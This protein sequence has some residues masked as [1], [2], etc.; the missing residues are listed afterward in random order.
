MIP[1]TTLE[2][3]AATPAAILLGPALLEAIV[4]WPAHYRLSAVVP[5]LTR[6]GHKVCR[7]MA[8]PVSNCRPVCWP[9]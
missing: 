7:P 9:C 3:M 6:L 1:L 8:P 2:Q 4:P 5:L